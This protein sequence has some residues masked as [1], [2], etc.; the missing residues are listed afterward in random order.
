MWDNVSKNIQTLEYSRV[1]MPLSAL[2]EGEFFNHYIKSGMWFQ[3]PA[4]VDNV[5]YLPHITRLPNVCRDPA[6]FSPFI[7]QVFLFFSSPQAITSIVFFALSALHCVIVYHVTHRY[8]NRPRSVPA[9][10][11]PASGNIMMLSEGRAGIESLYSL[12]DGMQ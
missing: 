7:C 8:L 11:K 9:I 5:I 12:K 3:N 10:S 1:I 6:T 4:V 2:L